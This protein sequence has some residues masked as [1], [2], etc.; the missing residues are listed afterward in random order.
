M[1]IGD[2]MVTKKRIIGIDLLK[3]VSMLGIIG[4]HIINKGGVLYFLSPNSYKHYIVLLLLT[5]LYSSVNIFA[6]ISGYLYVNQKKPKN[7]NIINLILIMLFY[8]IGISLVFYLFNFYDVRSQGF[9]SLIMNTFPF[10]SG[11]YW[12]IISYIF[13]F[14]MIPFLNLII[15][16]INKK[17]FK[18]ILIVL[19]I[20]LSIIP[21][22]FLN[23]D[24]FKTSYSY[25]PF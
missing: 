25:N 12:Y 21:T 22:L 10:L 24:L 1:I 4:L 7:K 5:F 11:R 13:V 6:I 17:Q 23:I 9:R 18:K 8:S 2:K 20:L 15:S 14:F 19:F 3:F 16:K